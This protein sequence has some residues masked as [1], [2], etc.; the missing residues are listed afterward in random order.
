MKSAT[1]IAFLG[2]FAF[3]VVSTGTL[4]TQQKSTQGERPKAYTYVKD[5][6]PIVSKYCLN[7]HG[8]DTENPSELFMDDFES[9]MKGGKHGVA[10]VPGKPTES[11]LYVKM[12]PDPPFGKQMP[13]GRKK[14]SPEEVQ[15][16]YDWIEQGAKE[17]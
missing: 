16:I 13:R 9:L 1:S 12:M 14:I 2:V 3:F 5:I 17:K 15:M 8:T 11:I 7:C 10:I 6:A 4:T